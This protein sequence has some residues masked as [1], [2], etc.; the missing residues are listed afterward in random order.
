MTRRKQPVV[1]GDQDGLG[2][3]EIAAASGMASAKDA[4]AS[5]LGRRGGLK[6]GPARARKM[7]GEERSQAARRAA[8]A[9]WH[10]QAVEHLAAH[11]HA[12]HLYTTSDDRLQQIAEFLHAGLSVGD[13]CL[14][15]ADRV[16]IAGI[17]RALGRRSVNVDAVVA[18][19]RLILLTT[20]RVYVRDGRFDP[21][22]TSRFWSEFLRSAQEPG[23]SGLRAAA[24]MGWVADVRMTPRDLRDYETSINK[25]SLIGAGARTICQFDRRRFMPDIL[26]AVLQTHRVVFVDGMARVNPFFEPPDVIDRGPGDQ[27]R[28]TWMIGRLRQSSP[29]APSNR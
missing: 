7:T 21:M 25:S 11:D 10:P 14:Y 1:D 16:V 20:D 6:G 12:A 24:D 23:V 9:R 18:S 22:H 26:H 2:D 5:E 15:I 4:I 29:P 13:R 17:I 8:N 19:G 3:L 27:A 28:I